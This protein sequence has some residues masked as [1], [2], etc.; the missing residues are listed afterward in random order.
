MPGPL[1][2]S[3]I[4]E[5]NSQKD[6]WNKQHIKY[7]ATD[8]IDKPTLFAQQVIDYFPKDGRILELGA[9]QGQD[10]RF[11]AS[12]GFT[13]TA[14]DFSEQALDFS[15]NKLPVDLTSKVEFQQIDLTSLL[16][17]PQATFDIIYSH[18]AL[19]YFSKERTKE[20]FDEIYTI[21]KPGG[22]FAILTNTIEDP[23]IAE[24]TKVDDDYYENVQGLKKRYFSVETLGAL[25]KKYDPIILD[26][27]GET[28]KDKIGSLIRFVGKKPAEKPVVAVSAIIE[29]VHKGE[30]EILIQTRHKPEREP[31]YTGTFELTQGKIDPYENVFDALKREV[32]EETGLKVTKVFPEIKTQVFSPHNDASFGFMPYFCIQQLKSVHGRPWIGFVFL[33]EVED[34][35]PI[36]QQTEVSAIAW[37]KKDDLKD[38]FKK[39]PK[40]FFTYNMG[41]LS[42]YF[43]NNE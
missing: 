42:Y 17:F 1:D 10:T 41:A 2:C 9:G 18:L 16:Q 30:K 39:E 19:H 8:W 20:L 22:I 21:L 28:H 40:K 43:Q 13:V 32:F 5:M 7:S 4:I 14:T 6:Y 36:P 3:I 25:T 37:M 31:E 11:F 34:K 12:R 26:S 33:C 29:R 27:R 15:R 35:E 24:L 23:E 38:L